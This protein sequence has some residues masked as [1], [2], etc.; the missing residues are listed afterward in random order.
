MTPQEAVQKT[1]AAEHAA[2]YLLGVIG[3]RLSASAQAQLWQRVR[4]SYT[5]HRGRR[6]QLVA[7]LRAVDADPV[8]A[9]VAYDLPTPARTPGQ[10]ERAALL[11]EE[12]CAA[13]YA[14]MVSHTARANR[15][16]A[17]DSLED[18]AV[19]L[20]GFGGEAEPFPGIGEL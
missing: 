19:R 3:A 11:V 14:D 17:L 13:V 18:S 12:R 2:V 7:M 10:L 4:E 6:D 9:E 20:L 16:W 1:L 8:A 15:Q 5:V